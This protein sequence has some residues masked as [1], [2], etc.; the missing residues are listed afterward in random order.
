MLEVREAQAV[1][2]AAIAR[3]SR[4]YKEGGDYVQAASEAAGE[5]YGYGQMPPARSG[6]GIDSG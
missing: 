2:A 1:W 6:A 3:I 5:L 4:T